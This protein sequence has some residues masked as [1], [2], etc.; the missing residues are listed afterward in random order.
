MTAAKQ[1]KRCGI[2]IAFDYREGVSQGRPNPGG[3][4]Q[5]DAVRPIRPAVRKL[6]AIASNPAVSS[7]VSA[8]GTGGGNGGELG[9]DGQGAP[10]ALRPTHLSPPGVRGGLPDR[11]LVVPP[12]IDSPGEAKNTPP[13]APVAH[14]APPGI[15][16]KSPPAANDERA[17]AP[18]GSSSPPP[19]RPSSGRKEGR[20]RCT[21]AT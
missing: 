15:A 13:S 3:P 2:H 6:D 19:C 16:V 11:R 20:R 17:A 7:S 9:L 18:A 8:D 4:D 21:R 10:R 14:A 12:V 5:G 1:A